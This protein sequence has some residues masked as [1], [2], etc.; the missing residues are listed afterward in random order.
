MKAPIKSLPLLVTLPHGGT[1]VPS[2]MA[3][4]MNLSPLERLID[5]DPRTDELFNFPGRVQSF[6]SCQM[7]RSIVDV[8]RDYRNDEKHVFRTHSQNKKPVWREGAYPNQEERRALLLAYY[9]PFHQR[10]KEEM[11]SQDFKL[12][13]DGHAMVAKKHMKEGHQLRPLFCI[14]NRGSKDPN[15]PEKNV[16]APFWLMKLL[17]KNFEE[18][19]AGFAPASTKEIVKINDPFRGGYITAYHGKNP[20]IPYVQ[21]EVN[22]SL[23]LPAEEA[24]RLEKTP[25]EEKKIKEVREGIFHVLSRTLAEI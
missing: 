19:F 10:I 4:R 13:I 22:R 12:A 15:Y 3:D 24:L 11:E 14:S 16:T 25:E 8:N 6:L 9:H 18:V 23:Y 7:A 17:K 5:S 1:G 20:D 2:H 21:I